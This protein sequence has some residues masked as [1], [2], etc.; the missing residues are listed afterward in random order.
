MTYILYVSLQL[1]LKTTIIFQITLEMSAETCVCLHV[2]CQCSV[3]STT[4]VN[5]PHTCYKLPLSNAIKIHCAFPSRCYS[6]TD[7]RTGM[8]RQKVHTEYCKILP[9]LLFIQLLLLLLLLLLLPPP[10]SH[11]PSNGECIPLCSITTQFNLIRTSRFR[12]T[13]CC[14]PQAEHYICHYR[15]YVRNT[16]IRRAYF[17]FIFAFG[18]GRK[19]Y[20]PGPIAKRT[21]RHRHHVDIM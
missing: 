18:N 5:C 19:S 8:A 4:P 1:F 9:L 13:L 16:D 6:R 14:H 15:Q 2:Q 7:R 21:K 3:T 10:P 20:A 12:G 11:P 17:H